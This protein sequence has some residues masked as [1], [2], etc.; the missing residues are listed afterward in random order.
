[1]R[2]PRSMQGYKGISRHQ[3]VL[4]GIGGPFPEEMRITIPHQG[5]KAIWFSRGHQRY[6]LD[7]MM[8]GRCWRDV[9]GG[10]KILKMD[11]EI[12]E[13]DKEL[14]VPLVEK[15]QGFV[16]DLGNGEEL[17]VEDVKERGFEGEKVVSQ[18]IDRGGDSCLRDRESYVRTS[19]HV[20]E[21]TWRIRNT[22]RFK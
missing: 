15:L 18:M 6:E 13:P 11:L 1:M 17:G 22:G 9:L 2:A 5:W 14:I 4:I 8:H 19:F 16:F 3:G 12:D 20:F 21:L 10:V 7:H